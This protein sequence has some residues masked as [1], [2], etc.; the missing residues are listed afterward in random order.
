MVSNL[1]IKLNIMIGLLIFGG[2]FVGL[3]LW[4]VYEMWRAPMLRENEDGT[5]TTIK[6]TKKLKDLF[7]R[8]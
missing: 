5:F 3:T 1:E 8:K 2:I 6:S 7:K 4:V